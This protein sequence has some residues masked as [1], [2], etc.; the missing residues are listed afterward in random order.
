MSVYEIKLDG[1]VQ[2][3]G[4]RPFV[5]RVAK[6]MNLKGTVENRESGVE[7]VLECN[8]KTLKRFIERIEREKPAPASLNKI[9]FD[10]KENKNNFKDFRIIKSEKKG[11]NTTLFPPDIA[12]CDECVEEMFSEKNIRYKYPFTSCAQCGPRFSIVSGL[13]YDRP[14]TTMKEFPMCDECNDEYNNIEDRRYHAQTNCCNECGPHYFFQ[15]TKEN[16]KI[17]GKDAFDKA[18]DIIN[19]NGVLAVKGIGG[20]HLICLP[21]ETTVKRLREKKQRPAKPFA[22]LARDIKTIES[23]AYVKDSEKEMLLSPARPI[24]LLKKKAFPYHNIAPDID[25]VGVMLPY[26]GIHHLLLQEFAV[27]IATSGN[28]SGEIICADNEEALSKL[29]GI[30]DG[31]LL[32]DR[33]IL[34]RCD[35]SVLKPTGRN[36][37]YIRKSRGFIP[38]KI[39]TGY[40]NSKE[41]LAF[42]ADMKAGFG[43]LREGAF[44]GSQ[45]LGD[46]SFK[47]NQETFLQMIKRFEKLFDFSPEIVVVDAH[48]NYFSSSLGNEY[49]SRKKLKTYQCQHHKAHVYSVMAENNLDECIG[50]SFDGT[51][52]GEDGNIWGGEFFQINGKNSKRIAHLRYVPLPGGDRASMNPDLMSSSYLSETGYAVKNKMHRITIDNST[53]YTSSAGRLF[54]AV[55]SILGICSYNTFEGEAPMKLESISNKVPRTLSWDLL[56]SAS[57][58]IID[59]EKIIR[60]LY[61]NKESENAATLA[62]IFHRTIADIVVK[63]CI[64]IKET[65]KIN[66]VCLSGGVFQNKLLLENCSEILEKAG[67]DV[68]Y[69]Q[70]VSPNDEGIALGQALW[71]SFNESKIS[72]T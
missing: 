44:L 27:L 10:Y 35:D 51:G 47:A 72:F 61:E 56:D 63:T 62:S 40:K 33:D 36:F 57:P 24:V 48:P 29:N 45:Y 58:W 64:K 65:T 68:Y 11:T 70:R 32:H 20:F 2:G 52:Y 13:P 31:F 54:D 15:K 46:L 38:E 39:E 30:S 17:Y 25:R 41:I 21:D 55:S 5:A 16:V 1:I 60:Y 69:N 26:A 49:A 28:I 6:S 9:S 8:E 22:L 53:L 43:F 14:F 50:V 12:M 66:N 59:W 67:L 3:V 71:A 23:F 37:I 18:V 42:G 4:F 34:N 19:N 7:I